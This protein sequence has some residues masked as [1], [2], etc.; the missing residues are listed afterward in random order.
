MQAPRPPQKELVPADTHLAIC[1]CVCDIGTQEVTYPGK[2]TKNVH[3]IRVIWEL[4]NCRMQGDDFDK[5]RVTGNDYTFST[6]E[7]SALAKLIIP[8]MGSC[9]DDFDFES[10]IGKACY[11]AIVHKK[12][13]STGNMYAR[14]ASAMK[15]PT[16][17]TVPA[18]ENASIFY[19]MTAMW[20]D[21]P[22]A[23]Q[24]ESYEWLREKI[25][26]S[27]EFTSPAKEQTQGGMTTE[28]KGEYDGSSGPRNLNPDYVGDDPPPV[29]EH[30]DIP[31]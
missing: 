19:D 5:P 31:F 9:P 24:T 28:Q 13:E 23:L 7:G 18:Q 17:V 4:P 29:D 14:I 6:Y 1:Y 20:K 30:D 22:T 15:V 26:E 12:S 11:L 25:E 21:Y 3:Q 10:L 16:G 2:P 8:W 27:K